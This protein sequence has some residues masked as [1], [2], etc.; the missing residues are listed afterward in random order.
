MIATD[1]LIGLPLDR[2]TAAQRAKVASTARQVQI[3]P[4]SDI[5]GRPTCGWMLAHPR[6]PG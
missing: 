4:A 3:G 1:P 5:R 2:L 6:W